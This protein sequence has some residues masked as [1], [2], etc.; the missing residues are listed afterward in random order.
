MVRAAVDGLGRGVQLV[1]ALLDR[2]PDLLLG[3]LAL[4][5]GGSLVGGGL[6]H[7]SAPPE[8]VEDREGEV[9]AGDPPV[10]LAVEEI[11]G[12]PRRHAVTSREVRAHAAFGLRQIELGGGAAFGDPEALQLRTPAHRLVLQ[13]QQVGALPGFLL[14]VALEAR[15]E[16]ERPPEVVIEEGTRLPDGVIGAHQVRL[17]VGHGHFRAQHVHFRGHAVA[18]AGAGHLGVQL[19]LLLGLRHQAAVALG[20][21]QAVIGA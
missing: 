9:H 17:S 15:G 11:F 5:P 14:E 4:Q 7:Q 18:K 13:L 2:K 8:P 19:L 1:V 10:E 12:K 3:L 16:I 20:P 21:Q 6:P